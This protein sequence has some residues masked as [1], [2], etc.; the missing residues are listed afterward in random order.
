MTRRVDWRKTEKYDVK[1]TALMDNALAHMRRV[2]VRGGL[3]CCTLL[4]MLYTKAHQDSNTTKQKPQRW[5]CEFDKY[6]RT[7]T[8]AIHCHLGDCINHRKPGR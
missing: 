6:S 5:E 1:T 3:L 7:N 8:I 2:E 4:R